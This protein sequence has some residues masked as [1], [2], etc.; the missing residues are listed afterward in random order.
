M[1]TNELASVDAKLMI[2]Q[3]GTNEA[4]R[5]A[6][7]ELRHS[8]LL[9]RN[10]AKQWRREKEEQRRR[11]AIDTLLT[12]SV[13]GRAA[14]CGGKRVRL[15]QCWV[16]TMGL[17]VQDACGKWWAAQSVVILLRVNDVPYNLRSGALLNGCRVKDVTIVGAVDGYGMIHEVLEV[18]CGDR[19]YIVTDAAVVSPSEVLS[20]ERCGELLG[21]T[22]IKE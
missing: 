17:Q 21:S 20:V 16:S 18:D 11:E 22:T 6:R 4:L 7:K 1:D 10:V 15:H 19:Q 3:L 5:C 2:D 9:Y 14:V 12:R 8:R 13:K